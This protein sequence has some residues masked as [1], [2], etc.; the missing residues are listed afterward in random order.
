MS[1][2]MLEASVTAG[3]FGPVIVLSGE[4]DQTCAGQLNALINGQISDG[5]RQ[6]TIDLSGLRFADSASIRTLVLAA[7]A[8]KER[9]GDLVLLHPQQ[10]VA[11]TLALTGA[12]QLITIRA[13]VNGTP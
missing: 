10:P 2:D 3:E 1:R 12:D 9:N 7:K 5:V 6:L 11:R 13:I 4:S 8:L